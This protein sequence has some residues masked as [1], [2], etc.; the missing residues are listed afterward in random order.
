MKKLYS[1]IT[2]IVILALIIIFFDRVVNFFVNIQWFKEMGYVPV[3]FTRVLATIK[4]MIP[5][6]ILCFVFIELYYRSIVNSIIKV[7]Q[8]I[9]ID[10]I[11]KKLYG[12]IFILIN[13][14]ISLLL[15]YIISS[16]YWYRILQ[17]TNSS[18][19]NT[20][21][22]IFGIDI[23]FFMFKLPLVESLYK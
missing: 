23:S 4:I 16:K 11:K 12:R 3:Y 9:E 18:N 17:M 20:K 7:K 13:V 15:S 19:F 22:P 5:I 6:F 8:H 10:K 2:G 1:I 21:D 14:L